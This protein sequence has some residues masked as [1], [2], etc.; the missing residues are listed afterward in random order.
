[1]TRARTLLIAVLCAAGP[2]FTA[3]APMVAAPVYD[4]AQ[5]TE[6]KLGTRTPQYIILRNLA[7]VDGD[8]MEK[9]VMFLHGRFTSN[10][11]C[12]PVAGEPD[13]S[14][15]DVGHVRANYELFIEVHGT[16]DRGTLTFEDRLGNQYR[17]ELVFKDF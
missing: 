12:R 5:R 15:C 10:I 7:R 8:S 4:G 1:M 3:C 14:R 16:V 11:V 13:T 17:Q 9:A 2:L 6:F